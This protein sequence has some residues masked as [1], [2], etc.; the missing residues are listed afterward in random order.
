M[1]TEIHP[2]DALRAQLIGSVLSPADAAYDEARRVHNGMI[3]RRPALLARCHG[4]A[5][6]QAAVRFEL[7]ELDGLIQ[8]VVPNTSG[9]TRA[10]LEDLRHRIDE[11]LK[12]KLAT[13]Q[14]TTTT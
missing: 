11:A 8:A 4:A 12:G 10:H 13:G 9:I 2:S 14:A 3:D 5:D 1:T 7:K 6:V